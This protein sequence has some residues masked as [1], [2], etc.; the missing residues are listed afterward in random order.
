MVGTGDVFTKRVLV[1]KHIKGIKFKNPGGTWPLC[2]RPWPHGK[3]IK[4]KIK[5]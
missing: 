5:N 3:L 4:T 1:E 2:R